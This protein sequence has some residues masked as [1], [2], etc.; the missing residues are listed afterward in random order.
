[1]SGVSD[2]FG[3]IAGEWAKRRDLP[4]SGLAEWNVRERLKKDVPRGEMSKG[5]EQKLRDDLDII[6]AKDILRELKD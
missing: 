2:L 6:K 3:Y 1:M 5:L 4:G